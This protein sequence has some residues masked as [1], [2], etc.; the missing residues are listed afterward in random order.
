M[1]VPILE[2]RDQDIQSNYPKTV[3]GKKK[4]GMP[5]VNATLNTGTNLRPLTRAKLPFAVNK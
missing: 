2:L 1:R 5:M 3:V 4:F